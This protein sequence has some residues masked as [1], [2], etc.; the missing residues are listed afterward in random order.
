MKANPGLPDD[1]STLRQHSYYAV[2]EPKYCGVALRFVEKL[3]IE[4]RSSNPSYRHAS[5]RS[6]Q[7]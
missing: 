7:S 2:R 4:I 5:K 6:Q 3:A 1:R